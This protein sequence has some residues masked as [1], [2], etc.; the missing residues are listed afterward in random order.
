M[1]LLNL[2]DRYELANDIKP[3]SAAQLRW[4]VKGLDKHLGRSATVADLAPDVLNGL[5]KEMR[6]DGR[7][8]A[9]IK[10]R[11]ANLLTLWRSARR[12][13]LIATRPRG[14][15]RIKLVRQA[16]VAW[17]QEEVNRLLAS[18]GT[19]RGRVRGTGL[20]AAKWWCAYIRTAWDTGLRRCDLFALQ[21]EHVREGWVTLVQQKTGQVIHCALHPSTLA[22]I[23]DLGATDGL[24]PW[25]GMSAFYRH[26]KALMALAGL[27][28]KPKW[29]RRSS[30]TAVE[31]AHPGQGGRHL[32]HLTPGMA[33]R[34]YFDQSILSKGK[35]MPPPLAG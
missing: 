10:N 21:P 26:F 24:L 31:L 28:G 22:A 7:S 25:R 12:M 19:L 29:L 2:V 5:L 20:P 13:K 4:A 32:G 8:S 30:G 1:R 18:A 3:S 15:R 33:E 9:T 17:T 11:R 34:H 27:K 6:D 14:V 23:R 35:P 16:P